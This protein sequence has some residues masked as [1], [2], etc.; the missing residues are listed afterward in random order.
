MTS[1]QPRQPLNPAPA[2]KRR[3]FP[4]VFWV[5]MAVVLILLGA[6][7]AR[8]YN[9]STKIFGSNVSFFERAR[10]LLFGGSGAP[11]QGEAQGQIN[12][13]LL[14]YGG[15]NHDGPYLT[16]S[17]ILASI[18]PDTKQI[19]LTSIPRDF[20]WKIS[21][22]GSG[23]KINEAFADGVGNKI[24]F[25]GGGASAIAAVE[26]VSGETIPYFTS[27]DFQGF[28][29]AVNKV[30]GLDVNVENTFTDDQYPNDATNGYLPPQ[31]FTAGQQ[32]MDG[33]RA[34]IFARSRHAA[35]VENGDFARSKRQEKIL[36]AFRDK[37][38][39]LNLVGNAGTYNSL[40]SILADHFHTNIEPAQVLHLAGMLKGANY[41]I[42]TQTLDDSTGLVCNDTLPDGAFVLDPCPG[43]TAS[44]IQGFFQN[45]FAA[46]A[47]GGEKASIII[48]N[49]GSDNALY[50]STLNDLHQAGLTIFEVPYSKGIPLATSVLYEVNSKP[51]VE[52]YIEDKLHIAAQPKPA[53][54]LAHADLVLLVGG[55]GN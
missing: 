25:S 1:E 47:L 27:L 7:L 11:L 55:P 40:L 6:G 41:Q 23:A 19:L 16:D 51:L 50:T 38:N 21:A 44:A 18:K 49:T 53:K 30:A 39:S 45:G 14:G 3:V 8:A 17:M 24:N 22:N 46:A 15:P 48:E 36:A 26:G 52:K 13:L 54:L 5:V 10:E 35:G 2:R 34:L 4:I 37:V 31:T 33:A 12:I 9:V 43:V 28:V 29:D 20:L 32:H 42:L